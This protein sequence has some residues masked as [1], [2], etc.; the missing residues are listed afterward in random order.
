[1]FER[2]G[3]QIAWIA[4]IGGGMVWI[5]FLSMFWVY[6]GNDFVGLT[7]LF[8]FALRLF[9]VFYLSPWRFPKTIS[10]FGRFGF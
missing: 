10:R 9:F 4:G 2:R 6:A 7:G 5:L 1:M 8:L 3:E